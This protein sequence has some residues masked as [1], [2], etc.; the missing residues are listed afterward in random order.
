TYTVPVP[1]F[2]YENLLANMGEMTNHGFEIGIRGDIVRTKDFTFNSSLNLS[3]QSNKLN[4]LSGTYKGQQLTT[5]E[6]IMVARINA[7]GL[8]QNYGV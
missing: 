4:S 1:P 8:T 2:T 3:F 6:H 5:S 7:A